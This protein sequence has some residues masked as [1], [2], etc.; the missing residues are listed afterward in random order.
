[1][2]VNF[3]RSSHSDRDFVA[4]ANDDPQY[5]AHL[6]F[7]RSVEQMRDGTAA[8]A[9]H[10]SV[11]KPHHEV[12]VSAVELGGVGCE[13]LMPAGA[14]AQRTLLYL[15]GGAFTRGSL[16]IGRGNASL[17]AAASGVRV[18]A[19]GYRQAPEQLHRTD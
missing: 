3:I 10:E 18:L 1:M 11:R 15:H 4:A 9:S 17:L 19:V 5:R 6:S 7:A 16:D 14:D 13:M 8:I 2:Q 12:L